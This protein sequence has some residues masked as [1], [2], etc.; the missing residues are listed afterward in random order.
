MEKD[1]RLAL[2]HIHVADL[3]VK[4]AHSPPHMRIIGADRAFIAPPSL[5]FLANAGRVVAKLPP[6]NIDFSANGSE[7]AVRTAVRRAEPSESSD[8]GTIGVP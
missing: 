3:A 8:S 1:D 7:A 2:S 6:H 5:L 4:N